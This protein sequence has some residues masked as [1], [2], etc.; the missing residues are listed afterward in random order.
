MIKRLLSF[1]PTII[2]AYK[3]SVSHGHNDRT[4]WKAGD[5]IHR[6]WEPRWG[7]GGD[8]DFIYS[9]GRRPISETVGA[10]FL[11][12][13]SVIPLG[14]SWPS[15]YGNVHE[16]IY[17]IPTGRLW[18]I[19]RWYIGDG[20]DCVGDD[21]DNDGDASE[22]DNDGEMIMKGDDGRWKYSNQMG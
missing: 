2:P 1:S 5:L 15:T 14:R 21:D 7:I 4:F 22:D 20:D 11:S 16:Y 8:D 13:V 3:A 12:N 19:V 10:N 6:K 9:G 18:F 17:N